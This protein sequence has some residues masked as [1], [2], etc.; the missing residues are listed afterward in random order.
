MMT[1]P[2]FCP[3]L[4][5]RYVQAGSTHYHFNFCCEP[6]FS[7]DND[8]RFICADKGIRGSSNKE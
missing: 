5:R 3:D 1:P 4:S 6:G 2:P 8:V 7:A